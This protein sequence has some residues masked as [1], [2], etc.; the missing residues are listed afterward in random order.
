M[1]K[2]CWIC[3]LVIFSV[4]ALAGCGGGGLGLTGG[5]VPIGGRAVTGTAVLPDG[6]AVASAAVAVHALPSGSV[7]QTS[8]TDTSGRFT[9]TGIPTGRDISVVI[10]Q[11]P[12]NT[13]EAVVPHATLAANPGTPLDIGA[14]TALTTVV[15]AAIHLEHGPAPEDS[16]GI[17]ANQQ[18]H[19]MM[20]VHASHYSIDMQKQFIGDPNSLNAQA[21]TL[22][23]PTANI[24][25][26]AFAAQP[27]AETASSALNGLLGYVRAAHKRGIHL[28]G[29]NRIA[30]IDAQLAGKVYSPDVIAAALRAANVQNATSVQVTSASLREHTELTA[31]ANLGAGITPFEA[32]VIAADADT[33]GGFQLDQRAFDTFLMELL[34]L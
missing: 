2:T 16:E 24:E 8:T 18:M 14:V 15:A 11:P 1:H 26:A 10:T 30:S 28:S 7:I 22:I 3:V 27:N 23:V 32:L 6:T 21:L 29:A 20:Q 34:K 12:S 4:F 17:V 13:L 9:F 25:L 5:S 19:L 31:L 33:H